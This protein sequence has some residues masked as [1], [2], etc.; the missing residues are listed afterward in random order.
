MVSVMDKITNMMESMIAMQEA[1]IIICITEDSD[2]RKEK[3]H[4]YIEKN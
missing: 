2:D 3:L 4:T 1:V